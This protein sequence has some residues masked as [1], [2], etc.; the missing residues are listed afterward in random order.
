MSNTSV[1]TIRTDPRLKA[2]AQEIAA[3]LGF[4]LSS[5]IKAYLKKLI[6]T[7]TLSFSVPSEEPSDY[8]IQALK[9][10]K[11]DRKPLLLERG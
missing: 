2:E 6:R 10:A 1:I 8:L 7:R 5:I 4:S 9:E 3:D 11:G